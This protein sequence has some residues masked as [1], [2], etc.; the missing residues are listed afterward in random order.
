MHWE[1]LCKLILKIL[2]FSFA[3]YNFRLNVLFRRF[4]MMD[5]SFTLTAFYLALLL[6]HTH[7]TQTLWIE[8]IYCENCENR[9]EY[10]RNMRTFA[11]VSCQRRLIDE[12]ATAILQ[13]MIFHLLLSDFA[14]GQVCWEQANCVWSAISCACRN[15][16]KEIVDLISKIQ[17][18]RL[19]R[20]W[21]IFVPGSWDPC[22]L[23]GS[24]ILFALEKITWES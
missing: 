15:A 19:D 12:S 8:H 18:Y 10:C 17:T 2:Q 3:S 14:F 4:S 6:H 22:Q 21:A 23:Q 7:D 9:E 11:F 24:E 20:V 5:Q 16:M 13:S 1:L